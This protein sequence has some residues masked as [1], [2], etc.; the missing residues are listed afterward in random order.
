LPGG[1]SIHYARISPGT[2][3]AD[4]VYETTASPTRFYK[5]RIAWD[6]AHFFLFGKHAGHSHEG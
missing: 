3:Y 4:A 1:G 2:G 5:S 6:G